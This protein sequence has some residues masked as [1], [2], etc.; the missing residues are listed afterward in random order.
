MARNNFGMCFGGGG[1]K[2]CLSV[3]NIVIMKYNIY[4]IFNVVAAVAQLQEKNLGGILDQWRKI[5]L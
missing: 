1:P 2:M 3:I 4:F 5:N